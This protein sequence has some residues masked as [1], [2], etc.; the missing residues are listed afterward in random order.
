MNE[1]ETGGSR[2]L[3][4]FSRGPFS[5]SIFV[6]GGVYLCYMMLTL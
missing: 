2:E 1:N 4:F 3:F 6:L 5:G